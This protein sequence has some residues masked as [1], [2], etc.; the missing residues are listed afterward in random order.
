MSIWQLAAERLNEQTKKRLQSAREAE[1][2]QGDVD[3]SGVKDESH[4]LFFGDKNSV[5]FPSVS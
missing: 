1:E 3:E 4:I 5:K 2:L